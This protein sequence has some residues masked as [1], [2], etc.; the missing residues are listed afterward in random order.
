[1]PNIDEN[2]P[3]VRV[4]VFGRRVEDFLESDIGVYLVAQAEEEYEDAVRQLL[5]V[6]WWRRRRIQALQN[7]AN[8]AAKFQKYLA[9]AV[10][11][12]HQAIQIIENEE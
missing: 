9:L 5:T 7:Q 4:A 3:T 10:Q 6:A 12:G 11:A 1:M 2:N 8:Q